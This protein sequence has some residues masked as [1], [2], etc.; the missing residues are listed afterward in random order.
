LLESCIRQIQSHN[1]DLNTFITLLFEQALKEAENAERRIK[2]GA[3]LGPLDGIPFSVKDMI[4]IKGVRCTAGSILFKNYIAKRNAI[5]ISRLKKAGAIIIGTTNLNEFASG[6]TGINPHYG[7]SKNP[8]NKDHISGGSS[9]G[10]C[11]SVST[12]M[13][14]FSLGTDTGGSIRVP[15]AFCGTV[16]LKPTYDLVARD[17]VINLAPSLDHVGCITRSMCDAA[18]VL[19]ALTDNPPYT[20]KNKKAN[21]LDYISHKNVSRKNKLIVGI[22]DDYF[23]ENIDLELIK[24]FDYFI[25]T[26]ESEVSNIKFISIKG[27]NLIPSTWTII[28]LAEAAEQHKRWIMTKSAE[29]SLEV[30]NMIK[31]GLGI[32]AVDYIHACKLKNQL[33]NNFLEALKATDVLVLP[34]TN[35]TA[36]KFKNFAIDNENSS[37]R[38]SLLRNSIPFNISGLPAVNVPVG[39]DRFGIPV[40]VQIVGRPFEEEIILS[41]GYEFEQKCNFVD[42]FIPPV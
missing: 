1:S 36:P 41:L 26:I 13:A 4:Q 8:W 37:I 28:R 31:K 24:H 18:I 19:E 12:G 29:Y 21:L 25:K 9:S 20:R 5:C 11:V 42:R 10:S 39:L 33:T 2:K 34:S 7:S 3:W 30:R 17:G 14:S 35:I 23:F 15:S 22:P 6:I 16:G 32:S 27:T 38:N 40:G